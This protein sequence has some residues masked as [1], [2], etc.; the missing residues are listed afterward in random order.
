MQNSFIL[1]PY[2]LDAVIPQL[3]DLIQPGWAVNKMAL[4]DGTQQQRM[5]I[6]HQILS[7][8]VN[9]TVRNGHR[10]ISFAGDCCTT[11]PVMAGLQRAD[12]DPFLIWFDAHGDFNTWETTP[13]GFLGGMPLA[14]LVGRGE[15]RM[16]A[17]VEMRTLDENQVLLTDGR[18]LDPEESLAIRD[19]SIHHLLNVRDV[20]HFD[21]PDRPLYVHFDTDVLNPDIAPAQNYPAHGG[22]SI[23][24]MEEV[25]H[26]LASSG[27]VVAVS[28]SSWN[29]ELAGA[30]ETRDACMHLLEVLAGD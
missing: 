19:S 9:T 3:E 25:F 26:Y 11:I 10:P 30:D 1:T 24:D 28:L 17:A 27:K 18:D 6:L 29:P 4:P 23:T 12:V 7:D 15:Q 16:V 5:S 8:W 13:S 21:L 22:P 20:L 2:F 14:M